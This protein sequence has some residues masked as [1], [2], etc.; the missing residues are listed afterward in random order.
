MELVNEE[1]DASYR[2][3]KEKRVALDSELKEV[4]TRLAKLYDALETGKLDLDD[5]APRIRELRARQDEVSKTRII[6]EA[7]MEMKGARHVDPE[8]VK[9]Y[10]GDLR[11]LLTD[12][13]IIK[14]KSFLR[15]F[16]KK[17]VINGEKGTIHYRLPVPTGWNEK[18]EIRVLPTV[19]PS[20][21][22]GTRTPTPCGT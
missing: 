19:P 21:E 14:S 8:L 6:L 10:A 15:S 22:G 7:E 9:T 20:G 18:E 16:V 17:I 4:N 12:M 5:L 13:D 1:I 2:V 3:Y 11:S